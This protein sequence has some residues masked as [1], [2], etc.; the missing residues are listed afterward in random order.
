MKRSD[1]NAAGAKTIEPTDDRARRVPRRRGRTPPTI[2]EAPVKDA[3][4][5]GAPA[6]STS[7]WTSVSRPAVI[8]LMIVRLIPSGSD[9][10]RLSP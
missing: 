8:W 4:I 10:Q 3:A 2:A 5:S 7:A 9:V 1:R 6:A